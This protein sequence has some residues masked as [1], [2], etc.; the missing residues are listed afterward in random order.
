[1]RERPIP[2]FRIILE[3]TFPDASPVD[4]AGY[5]GLI[6]RWKVAMQS[7]PAAPCKDVFIRE[8]LTIGDGSDYDYWRYK[9]NPF[10]PASWPQKAMGRIQ[11]RKKDE[12]KD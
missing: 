2:R 12:P 10:D 6:D 8:T 11:G 4:P 9:L 1:M 7:N 3:L 5:E